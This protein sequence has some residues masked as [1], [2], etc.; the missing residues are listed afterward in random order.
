VDVDEA[1]RVLLLFAD[2]RP[3]VDEAVVTLHRAET[4]IAE[5]VRLSTLS[6]SGVEKMLKRH[7]ATTSR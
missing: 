2:V 1:R 5:I 3:R 7:E 6:R 4:P